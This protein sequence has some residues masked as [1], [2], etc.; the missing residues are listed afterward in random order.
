MH[1]VKTVDLQFIQRLEKM[2]LE[3]NLDT[4]GHKLLVSLQTEY[5]AQ[6]QLIE[7]AKEDVKEFNVVTKQMAVEK[8][9]AEA[10][11]FKQSASAATINSAVYSKDF[12]TINTMPQ[13]NDALAQYSTLIRRNPVLVTD[14]AQQATLPFTRVE[15]FKLGRQTKAVEDPEVIAV[16][17]KEIEEL[18]EVT[19]EYECALKEKHGHDFKCES[20]TEEQLKEVKTKSGR[21]ILNFMNETPEMKAKLPPAVEKQGAAAKDTG[22][23]KIH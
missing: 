8:A 12:I 15:L 19:E 22:A 9:A 21:D 18:E 23:V 5:A 7:M 11:V 6:E 14:P 3:G 4:A 17:G 20:V 13:I 1:T 2:A 10:E 16:K